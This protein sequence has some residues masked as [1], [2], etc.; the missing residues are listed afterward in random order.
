MSTR[1]DTKYQLRAD[2][3]KR[4]KICGTDKPA[5]AF[6]GRAGSV[7][8]L[9]ADCKDCI[10]ARS[11]RWYDANAETAK[12]RA[13]QWVI[14]NPERARARRAKWHAENGREQYLKHREKRLAAAAAARKADPE[15]Y[16]R[17]DLAQSLR[18]YG[19]TV[20]RFDQ[21]VATQ[22]GMCAICRRPPNG[23]G[24]R[25]HVDHDHV[26]GRVRGLL[27]HSCNTSIGHLA[28]SAEILARAIVYLTSSAT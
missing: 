24:R 5:A 6:Y 16:R 11:R 21:M 4:C 1:L 19:L 17:I 20:E 18:V 7:D 13:R 22:G 9:R 28:E 8:G 2:G 12:E 25:L 27:C 14:D 23:R 26:S 15:K 10:K 3:M